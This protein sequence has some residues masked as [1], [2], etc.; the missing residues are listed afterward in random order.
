MPERYHPGMQGPY[1]KDWFL[2]DAGTDSYRCPMAER[3]VALFV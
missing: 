1:S 2:Y 3:Q